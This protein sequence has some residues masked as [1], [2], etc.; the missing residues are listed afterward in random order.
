MI[1]AEGYPEH[2]V[3]GDKIKIND[4]ERT[5]FTRPG[6]PDPPGGQAYLLHAGTR[7]RRGLRHAGHGAAGRA[8]AGRQTWCRRAAGC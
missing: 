7:G 3:K 5:G 4:A 8:A 2:P 6:A 1:A